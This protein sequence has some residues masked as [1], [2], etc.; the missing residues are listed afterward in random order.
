MIEVDALSIQYGN[1]HAIE[2]VSFNIQ[3]GEVV[4]LLGHNGAGKTTIMKALTGF[5]EPTSG[6]VR[7]QDKDVQKHLT[8]TQKLIG[9]LPENCP[10][11][12]EMLVIEYLEYVAEL[13]GM[14]QSQIGDKVAQ[15]IHRTHLEEKALALIST[16][17]RGYRQR[18]GVAQAILHEPSILILDEPTNG[19]DP[20]QIED[21]RSLIR[22]LSMKSTVILST[23]ILQEVS[24]VC[25]RVL[26]LNRGRLALD[27]R[28]DDLGGQDALELVTNAELHSLEQALEGLTNKGDI[29]L[30]GS[31]DGTFEYRI[32]SNKKGAAPDIARRIVERGIALHSLSPRRRSLESVFQDVSSG[33][34]QE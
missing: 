10:T 2:G 8:E 27:A 12:P 17:S 30:E 19:L 29:R 32:Q 1:F 34:A 28:L 23:H 7:I 9:Y 25:E 5:L 11:Y 16:L 18:V 24:A 22:E 33:S 14:A 6:A 3:S 20:N 26:I 4:G 31:L 13:R 15:A 21:M